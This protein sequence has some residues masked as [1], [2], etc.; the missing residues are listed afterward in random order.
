M[1][2]NIIFKNLV[3]FISK[4]KERKINFCKTGLQ[5]SGIRH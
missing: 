3:A 2:K 4:S 5:E 1:H